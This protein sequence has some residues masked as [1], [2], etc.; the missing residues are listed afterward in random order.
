MTGLFVLLILLFAVVGPLVLYAVIQS[1]TTG[2]E[3]L[4]RSE[5]ARRVRNDTDDGDRRE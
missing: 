2:N 4:D 1:E 5:A 3:V